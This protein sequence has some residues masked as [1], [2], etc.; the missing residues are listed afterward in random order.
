MKGQIRYHVIAVG[1]GLLCQNLVLNLYKHANK[2]NIS[3]RLDVIKCTFIRP[4]V[5]IFNIKVTV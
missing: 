1:A 3:C 4:S 5:I 2:I